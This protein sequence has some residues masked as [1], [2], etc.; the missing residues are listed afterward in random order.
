M[1]DLEEMGNTQQV[2]VM[3]TEDNQQHLSVIDWKSLTITKKMSNF[4]IKNDEISA[5][6]SSV[7]AWISHDS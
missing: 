4:H 6:T 3:N 2:L 1:L 5:Q 7:I